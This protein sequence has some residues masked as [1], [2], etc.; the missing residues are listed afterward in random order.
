MSPTTGAVAVCK[1]AVHAVTDSVFVT[2]FSV[3]RTLK[4]RSLGGGNA[5]LRLEFRANRFPG[6]TILNS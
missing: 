4:L 6:F 2:F 5:D 1:Q 3:R